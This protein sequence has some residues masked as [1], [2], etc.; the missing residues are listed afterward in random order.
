LGQI[1]I[2]DCPCPV[3]PAAGC[4]FAGAPAPVFGLLSSFLKSIKDVICDPEAGA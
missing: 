1:K 2:V 4:Y 3:V